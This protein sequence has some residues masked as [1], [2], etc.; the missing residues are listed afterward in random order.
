MYPVIDTSKI[1]DLLFPTV[2]FA[3][4]LVNLVVQVPDL[5]IG[6]SNYKLYHEKKVSTRR[7][8]NINY[9]VFCC[10]IGL[11][12]ILNLGDLLGNITNAVAAPLLSLGE[13]CHF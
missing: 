2:L 5:E 9:I 6:E 8:K 1:L 7:K 4:Q 12:T 13:R 3:H 10:A 11:Y